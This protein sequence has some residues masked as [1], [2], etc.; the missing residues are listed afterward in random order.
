MVIGQGRL[1]VP[2]N[3]EYSVP[4]LRMLLR[5]IEPLIGRAITIEEWNDIASR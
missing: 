1:T 3:A 2:T 5:E 4:Q